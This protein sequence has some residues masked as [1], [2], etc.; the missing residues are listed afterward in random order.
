[1]ILTL[2]SV[3]PIYSIA[4][5]TTNPRGMLA[6]ILNVEFVAMNRKAALPGRATFDSVAQRYNDARQKRP[7]FPAYNAVRQLRAAYATFAIQDKPAPQAALDRC[8][9]LMDADPQNFTTRMLY[10]LLLD[11][12]QR[13]NN[14]AAPD[15]I[16]T[17]QQVLSATPALSKCT[18]YDAEFETVLHDAFAATA[19]RPDVAASMAFHWY[20]PFTISSETWIATL[21]DIAQQLGELRSECL[22]AG[23]AQAADQVAHWL[24]RFCVGIIE[25]TSDDTIQ[26][27]AADLLAK[28]V[29]DAPEIAEPMR[30]LVTAHTADAPLLGT[31]W[32]AQFKTDPQTSYAPAP[33]TTAL[34]RL[35]A[36]ALFATLAVSAAFGLVFGIAS[37]AAPTDSSTANSDT[38]PSV[39]KSVIVFIGVVVLPP[40]A[41]AIYTANIFGS[42]PP[43]YAEALAFAEAQAMLFLGLSLMLIHAILFAWP[44]RDWRERVHRAWPAVLL[45]VCC[46]IFL[47][48][49]APIS[50]RWLRS[51]NYAFPQLAWSA[52]A[53]I[54]FVMFAVL[55]ARVPARY[56][57]RSAAGAWLAF[58]ILACIAMRLHVSADHD[59]QAAIVAAHRDSM[60][61]RIGDDWREKYVKPVKNAL[62]PRVP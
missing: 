17:V 3:G 48:I 21:P 33:Y 43:F 38:R 36:F 50:T 18:T 23:D 60:A 2:A 5:L 12:R 30:A 58:A 9:A 29:G 40:V 52:A 8:A 4:G 35:F 46:A 37:I 34:E 53:M 16:H 47:T 1:M 54:L 19:D 15:R 10:A 62:T 42:R 57:A 22:A 7:T 51:L 24:T 31:D 55:V 44:Q 32:A 39:W 13:R 61:A 49:P 14:A 11:D 25:S 45:A 28:H 59:Y 26:C 20:D 41:I 27:L 56:L 6:A